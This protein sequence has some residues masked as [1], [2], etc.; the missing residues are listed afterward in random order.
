MATNPTRFQERLGPRMRMATELNG[1]LLERAQRQTIQSSHGLKHNSALTI[2][3]K[4][5][6]KPLV[7]KGELFQAITSAIIDNYTVVVGVPQS[8]QKA[9]NVATIVADGAAVPV[10]DKM[11]GMF[12]ALW[13]AAIGELEPGRLDGR[14]K[15]LWEQSKGWN[16][17]KPLSP[18]TDTIIIPARPWHEIAAKDP[19][20][21]KGVRENWERAIQQTFHDLAAT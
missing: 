4:G 7:A 12:F 19:D 16:G 8:N 21:L 13:K 11:R 14:A 15:E 9:Y 5:S 18:D 17:W 2:A 1:K 20:M 3:I 6:S 10:T